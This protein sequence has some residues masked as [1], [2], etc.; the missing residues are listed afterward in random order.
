M[1]QAVLQVL[2]LDLFILPQKEEDNR[3]FF[4][5]FQ[6]H[7]PYC[8]SMQGASISPEGYFKNQFRID[9]EVKNTCLILLLVSPE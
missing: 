6:P 2:E 5:S 1:F 4:L 9:L 3:L 7:R 8:Q